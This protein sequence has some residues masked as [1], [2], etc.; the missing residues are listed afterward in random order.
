MT[1]FGQEQ[2]LDPLKKPLKILFIQT[3]TIILRLLRSVVPEPVEPG[4]EVRD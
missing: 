2:T 3:F 4:M 1:L